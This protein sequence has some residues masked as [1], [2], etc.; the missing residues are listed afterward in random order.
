MLTK[1][2]VPGKVNMGWS[3]IDCNERASTLADTAPCKRSRTGGPA[4]KTWDTDGRSKAF[5]S[6][7][8]QS[9][10]PSV[11]VELLLD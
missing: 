6:K 10:S 3:N 7:G 5:C 2:T 4:N 8:A 1:C 11:S 9:D